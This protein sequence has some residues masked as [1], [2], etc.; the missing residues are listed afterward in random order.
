MIARR[1][2]SIKI[3]LAKERIIKKLKTMKG[4]EINIKTTSSL[5]TGCYG[6][7][8]TDI[9][10]VRGNAFL[11]VCGSD[12]EQFESFKFRN[13]LDVGDVVTFKIVD[14]ERPSH[15]FETHPMD[16]E[17]LLQEYLKLKLELKE[18]GIL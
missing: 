1:L 12:Y 4:I 14:M 16:R 17:L 3:C 11:S 2:I 15:I 13:K 5:I 8:W 18:A 10:L 7:V 6:L 9:T